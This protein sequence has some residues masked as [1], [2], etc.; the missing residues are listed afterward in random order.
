MRA[1]GDRPKLTRKTYSR[2]E[3]DL[4]A[5]LE[6]NNLA[7]VRSVVA[8]RLCVL[9]CLSLS[10]C[11]RHILHRVATMSDVCYDNRKVYVSNEEDWQ[12]RAIFSDKMEVCV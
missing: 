10:L 3:R 12:R 5:A 6:Q 7:K 4:H 2:F 9:L 8:V 1:D 11:L